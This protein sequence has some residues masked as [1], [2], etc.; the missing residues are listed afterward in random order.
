M[1]LIVEFIFA[2]CLF[3]DYKPSEYSFT[4]ADSSVLE[5]LK[6]FYSGHQLEESLE[7]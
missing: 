5:E 4:T 2:Y 6:E 1:I 3:P 7:Q